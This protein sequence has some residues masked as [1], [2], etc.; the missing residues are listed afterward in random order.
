LRKTVKKLAHKLGFDIRRMSAF[1]NTSR[2]LFLALT[3]FNIDLVFDI[4]ANKGQF[5]EDLRSAG[6]NGR[7]L[8]FE[9]LSTAHSELCDRA[10]KDC[11]WD[12]FPRC[13][14]G[15]IDGQS[16]INISGN[17]LSS[18]ILPILNTHTL[19]DPSSSY[20]SHESVAIRRLDSIALAH[21][22]DSENL[23]LKIDTQGFEWQVLDGGPITLGK[24]IGL[25]VE[26]SLA[27][28]YGGQR[29]WKDIV[30]RLESDGFT[31]FALQNGFTDPNDGRTL[32]L[33]AIFFRL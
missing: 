33:D 11:N 15:N 19:A 6:Y 29:L 20:L 27:P 31:L 24:A 17:S 7:I 1:S 5:A 12:V 23:F 13:A 26:V 10:S 8:S 21:I 4:G 25:Q 14:L 16:H 22:L 2:Q 9:P 28:L 18:S 30:A 3:R 32:Q